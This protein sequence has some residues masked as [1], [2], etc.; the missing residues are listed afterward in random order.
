MVHLYV[1][2]EVTD[3]IDGIDLEVDPD[4][5][6]HILADVIDVELIL[7]IETGEGSTMVGVETFDG[8]PSGNTFSVDM[9]VVGTVNV[10]L[11]EADGEEEDCGTMMVLRGLRSM[12][13]LGMSDSAMDTAV[14]GMVAT[15]QIQ[16]WLEQQGILDRD[17]ANDPK[18]VRILVDVVDEEP[19]ARILADNEEI[20]LTTSAA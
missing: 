13:S 18:N 12:P 3:Y 9:G 14:N 4:I 15:L 11:R 6:R 19:V 1:K 16:Q 10:R 2:S 5:K 7:E 20:A 17:P 8:E